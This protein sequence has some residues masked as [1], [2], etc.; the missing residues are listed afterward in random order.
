MAELL[1]E[2]AR[3]LVD[4]PDAVRVEE[5]EGDDGSLVLRLHVAEG[6]VGKVIGRQGRI[7]RAL[8]TIVRAGGPSAG[9]RLQLEIVG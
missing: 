2:L 6:D 9:Q 5:V 4:E 7:A 8:R 3:R 1:A